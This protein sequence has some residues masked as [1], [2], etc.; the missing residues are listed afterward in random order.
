MPIVSLRRLSEA[1]RHPVTLS[2][3]KGLSSHS[4]IL[5]YAC[6]PTGELRMTDL[7]PVERPD[8][9]R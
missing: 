3:A 1:L 2:V 5:R 6:L 9:Q 4:E 8:A 7:P